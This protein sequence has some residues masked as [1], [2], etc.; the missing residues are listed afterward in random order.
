[1]QRHRL[2]A[3][4]WHAPRSTSA[5]ATASAAS[6]PD[7]PGRPGTEAANASNAPRLATRHTVTTVKRSTPQRSAAS[8]WVACPV[9]IDIHISYFSLGANHRRGFPPDT[10]TVEADNN[11]SLQIGQTRR[12]LA[13]YF[14]PDLVH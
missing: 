2:L 8:R 3:R 7:C 4:P 11:N 10:D 14:R 13:G 12:S 6:G 1:M 5:Q 9:T